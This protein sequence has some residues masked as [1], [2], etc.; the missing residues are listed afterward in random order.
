MLH[1]IEITII[2]SRMNLSHFVTEGINFVKITVLRIGQVLANYLSHVFNM[3]LE[4][5]LQFMNIS[6]HGSSQHENLK[7]WYSTNVDENTVF[8]NE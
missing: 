2:W 7:D 1:L 3:L 6:F 8:E 5:A 4:I